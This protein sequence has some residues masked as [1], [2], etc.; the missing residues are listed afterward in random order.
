[1]T[2]SIPT[3]NA[4][5]PP[6]TPSASLGLARSLA[7]R[8]SSLLGLAS[9][10]SPCNGSRILTK[11]LAGVKYYSTFQPVPNT[12][13]EG[14][15]VSIAVKKIYTKEGLTKKGKPFAFK[16]KQYHIGSFALGSY[17][18]RCLSWP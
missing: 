17:P 6:K 12:I 1:M 14:S 2:R 7:K 8:T 5:Q 4:R 11:I 16:K 18:L 15:R 13:M 3:P 9:A 10:A